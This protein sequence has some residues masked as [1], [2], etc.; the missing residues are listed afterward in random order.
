MNILLLGKDE[1]SGESVDLN[2]QK[3][4]KV[5]EI[6]DPKIKGKSGDKQLHSRGTRASDDNIIHVDEDIRSK[7]R[8]NG[9]KERRVRL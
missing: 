4:G 2:T 1:T 3:E 5:A 7:R 6:L 8:A 9:D